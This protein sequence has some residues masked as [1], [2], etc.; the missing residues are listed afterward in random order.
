MHIGKASITCPELK[1]HGHLMEKVM[2]DKYLGDIISSGG[3]NS[4][5]LKERKGKAIGCA[6]D[7]MS[8]LETISFGHQYFRIL[9]LLREA[10]FIN[11]ILTN[12]DIWFRLKEGDL[13]EL[14][15]IYRNLLR[16]ALKCP[17]TTP[18]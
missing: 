10:M 3:S 2:K 16:R 6:N 15:D 14:E 1:I 12:A 5:T 4:A 9:V 18:K 8:I 7:I 13:K 11:C 17:S